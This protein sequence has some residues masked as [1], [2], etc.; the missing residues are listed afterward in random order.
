MILTFFTAV[1][2]VEFGAIGG[3][4][5]QISDGLFITTEKDILADLLSARTRDAIGGLEREFLYAAPA[6]IYSR[7]DAP[8]GFDWREYLNG[9]MKTVKMFFNVMWLGKDNAANSEL[10]FLTY[11]SGLTQMT[12]SNAISV[13]YSLA[14]GSRSL[15]NFSRKEL[16]ETRAF[17]RSW[18]GE[19]AD[20]TTYGI[21]DADEIGRPMRAFY[22]VQ[23]GR[24]APGLGQR[25]A[26][27][28]TPIE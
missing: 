17:Y 18:V 24:A 16:Q 4:G 21:L 12:H 1:I 27:F 19:V 5:D 23:A 13:T 2:D 25:F 11:P 7:R 14:D 3:R 9:S 6:I 22:W 20:P 28:C 15:V 8:D 10:G 26:C